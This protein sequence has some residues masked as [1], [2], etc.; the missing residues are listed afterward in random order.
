MERHIKILPGANGK[1]DS[2]KGPHSRVLRELAKIHPGLLIALIRENF[3]PPAQKADA[4]LALEEF[5][6]RKEE[7]LLHLHPFLGSPCSCI[8]RATQ[9]TLD[10]PEPPNE[11]A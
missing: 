11:Q 6:G 1:Q 10:L 3:L 9:T 4:I 7:L 5:P 8:R 2:P